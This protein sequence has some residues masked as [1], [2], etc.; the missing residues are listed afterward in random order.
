MGLKS[1]GKFVLWDISLCNTD[2]KDG[3]YLRYRF[4][5]TAACCINISRYSSYMYEY[6]GMYPCMYRGTASVPVL[7]P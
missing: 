7:V 2:V 3:K 4:Y 1:A 6:L 5:S